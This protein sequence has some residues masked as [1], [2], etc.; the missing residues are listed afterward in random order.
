MAA[1]DDGEVVIHGTDGVEH[2][3]PAGVDLQKA[4]DLVL[5]NTKAG[6]PESL[7]GPAP[8]VERPSARGAAQNAIGSLGSTIDG[9]IRGTAHVLGHPEDAAADVTAGLRDRAKQ[10]IQ[11]IDPSAAATQARAGSVGVGRMGPVLT[12]DPSRRYLSALS[13]LLPLSLLYRDPVGVGMD[14]TLAADA[15]RGVRGGATAVVGEKAPVAAGGVSGLSLTPTGAAEGPSIFATPEE[16][17]RYLRDQPILLPAQQTQFE[18]LDALLRQK[19]S[20]KGLSYQ[21]G[22]APPPRVGAPTQP[23]TTPA[24]S[25]AQTASTV[26][27]NIRD[28]AKRYTT[29]T[30]IH[31]LSGGLPSSVARPLGRAV[32]G[33]IDSPWLGLLPTGAA[34]SRYSVP[35]GPTP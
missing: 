22:G 26:P 28:M 33:G 13:N 21:S 29:D 4:R 27:P 17:Y 15:A 8:P 23:P 9:M 16:H 1:E 12:T 5:A 7:A 18:N 6:P 20:A 10:Y 35:S 11:D 2:H 30:L 34:W 14:A 3:F 19:A 32:V 25:Q 31:L 24:G